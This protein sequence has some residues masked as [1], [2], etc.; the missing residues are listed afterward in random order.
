MRVGIIQSNYMPWR[1]YFDF[2]DDVDLFIFY[3]DV[4]YTH[5][6]W[7]NRNRIKTDRGLMWLSVPV[8]HN[9]DT[10]ILEAEIDY[11]NRWVDKQTRSLELAYRKAPFF[12]MYA[13]ELFGILATR[14]RTISALNIALCKWVM[15]QLGIRTETRMS[16]EFNVSGNKYERPMEILRRASATAYLSGPTAR[17]YVDVNKYRDAGVQLEW[18]SYDYPEYPQLHGQFEPGVTVLDLLFNCG[19]GARDYLKSTTPNEKAF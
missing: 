6:D 18:K 19:T 11:Q 1:G 3:D 12:T 5:R 16:S 8:K 13:E 15:A 9:L 4:Q 17:P 7:G 10:L 14:F 2:I